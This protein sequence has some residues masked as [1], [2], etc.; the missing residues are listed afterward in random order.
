MEKLQKR[1]NRDKSKTPERLRRRAG[2]DGGATVSRKIRHGFW[3]RSSQ[4]GNGAHDRR[5]AAHGRRT[6]NSSVAG[7]LREEAP[8]LIYGSSA[9]SAERAQR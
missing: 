4:N 8:A 6:S 3:L 9:Q 5:Q 2:K 1:N 7:G